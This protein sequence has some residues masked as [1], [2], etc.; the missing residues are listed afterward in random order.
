MPRQI[1]LLAALLLSPF[2]AKAYEVQSFV[3]GDMLRGWCENDHD[4]AA[5]YIMGFSDESQR[6]KKRIVDAS[7]RWPERSTQNEELRFYVMGSFC[8]PGKLSAAQATEIAC[9][10]LKNNPSK[11]EQPAASLLPLAYKK[12]FPCLA[13]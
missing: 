5:A 6:M 1:F 9:V 3:S 12:A 10:W 4:A 13:E 8:L 11:G 7:R 2:S